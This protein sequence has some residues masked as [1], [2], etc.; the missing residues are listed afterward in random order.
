MSD[1]AERLHKRVSNAVYGLFRELESE[2]VDMTAIPTV[3]LDVLWD[4]DTV[5]VEDA[6]AELA[7]EK[8]YEPPPE[9][10]PQPDEPV[11]EEAPADGEPPAEDDGFGVVLG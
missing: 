5:T 1:I 7:W 4:G 11:S 3:H 2:G 10:E 8:V 9:P 6:D